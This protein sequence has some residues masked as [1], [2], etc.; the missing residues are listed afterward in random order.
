[1]RLGTEFVPILDPTTGEP[2]GEYEILSDPYK[3]GTSK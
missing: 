3:A 2:T 1:M